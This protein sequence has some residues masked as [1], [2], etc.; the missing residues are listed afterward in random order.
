MEADILPVNNPE[1]VGAAMAHANDIFLACQL[2]VANKTA[3]GSRTVRVREER[4]SGVAAAARTALRTGKPYPSIAEN[5]SHGYD[6][7]PVPMYPLVAVNAR[8]RDETIEQLDA[9]DA[10]RYYP[11][12][13]SDGQKTGK[14][15]AVKGCVRYHY[16]YIDV[17]G[18]LLGV[19]PAAEEFLGDR[20]T[21]RTGEGSIRT[22]VLGLVGTAMLLHVSRSAVGSGPPL[23]FDDPNL[24]ESD[25][26][27][28][29][30]DLDGIARIADDLRKSVAIQRAGD[31]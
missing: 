25:G 21:E 6:A 7:R 20:L 27:G 30:F 8:R 12:V 26:A 31:L 13:G 11:V 5:P 18:M 9:P 24:P 14:Y 2:Q 29:L 4:L 19:L 23:E 15:R 10:S 17:M 28:L 16:R 3:I 22:R 1:A